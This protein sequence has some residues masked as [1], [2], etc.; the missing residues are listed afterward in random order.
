MTETLLEQVVVKSQSHT[1]DLSDLFAKD[2]LK[3]LLAATKRL[4]SVYFY[5][6]RGS[7]LFEDICELDEYYLTRKE[8]EILLRSG[9]EIIDQLPMNTHLVELGSGSSTKTRILLEAALARFENTQYSPIDVSEEIL[10][11]SAVGLKKRYPHLQI[12]AIT[13]RYEFGL[14]RILKNRHNPVCI[15]WL[16]SSIG[17]LTRQAAGDFLNDIRDQLQEDDSLL[18]GIDLRKSAEILEPAY[19]DAQGFTAEFNLNLLKRIN[20]ELGGH[21]ELDRFHH[22]AV[23]NDQE[24]RVEMYLV[25]DVAQEVQ[26]D[27][28]ETAVCFSQN[29]HILTEYSYKYSQSEIRNLAEVSGFFLEEQ[30]LDKAAWFSLNLFKSNHKQQS[31]VQNERGE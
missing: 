29:E 31:R 5:D 25:S 28:L 15:M 13:G 22:K 9:A 24:G 19:D 10:T 21:F 7:Q 1:D 27:G 2:V 17:N 11:T 12:K 18:L 4:S 23:Y 6:E 14:E 16:G 30:W 8:T 20:T 26:I 3:G